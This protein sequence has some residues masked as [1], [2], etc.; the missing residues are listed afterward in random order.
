[1]PEQLRRRKDDV[2]E[3]A[4]KKGSIHA[5]YSEPDVVE[6]DDGGYE[7]VRKFSWRKLISSSLFGFVIAWAV[8]CTTTIFSQ[9]TRMSVTSQKVS[10]I[11]Q[12]LNEEIQ[13]RKQ[14][15]TI[16][17]QRVSKV[18]DFSRDQIRMLHKA[19][20]DYRMVT[21]DKVDNAKETLINMMIR[22]LENQEKFKEEVKKADG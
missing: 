21:F 1:M 9:D 13:E 4:E 22:I 7:I 17:H 8:W 20:H 15:D 12:N 10:G 19:I 11:T 6:K 18:D 5:L 14:M 3:D 16:L 2:L